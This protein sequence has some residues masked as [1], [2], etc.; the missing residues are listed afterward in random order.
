M[1]GGGGLQAQGFGPQMTPE[2]SPEAS[3]IALEFFRVKFKIYWNLSFET[4]FL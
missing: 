2:L 3:L 4:F 1:R